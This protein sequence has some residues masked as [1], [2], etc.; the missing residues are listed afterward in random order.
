[1]GRRGGRGGKAQTL[2]SKSLNARWD[3]E[4]VEVEKPASVPAK[5]I[6]KINEGV[7]QGGQ[8]RAAPL[9]KTSG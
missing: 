2:N 9:T 8:G 1:V 4:V 3:D 5:E 6:Q 7:D